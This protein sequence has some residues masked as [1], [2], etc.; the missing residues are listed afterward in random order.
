[1]T[2]A[3]FPYNY[4]NWM[5]AQNW[6]FHPISEGEQSVDFLKKKNSSKFKKKN[7]NYCIRK[8]H[9]GPIVSNNKLL[10]QEMKRKYNKHKVAFGHARPFFGNTVLGSNNNNH[11]QA[12]MFILSHAETQ[13]PHVFDCCRIL[14]YGTT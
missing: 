7:D 12:N 9:S 11:K 13:K 3:F 8:S 14:Y 1:M 5:Y 2:L 10:K 4:A 6:S